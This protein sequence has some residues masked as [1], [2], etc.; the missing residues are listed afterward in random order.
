MNITLSQNAIKHIKSM[1]NKNPE[2]IIV[3]SMKQTGCSGFEYSVKLETAS[4]ELEIV[5]HSGLVVGFDKKFI[6]KF[7]GSIIDYSTDKFES[8]F[9]FSNPNVKSACGC[10][11]SV[12]F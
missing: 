10:G 5:E 4:N 8:K 2:K 12:S 1:Y 6:D 11:V 3:F 7:E 9:V